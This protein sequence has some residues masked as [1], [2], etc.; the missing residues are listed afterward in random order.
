MLKMIISAHGGIVMTNDGNAILRE[1]A[2]EHPA[3][4]LLLLLL[5]LFVV[6][7]RECCVCVCVCGGGGLAWLLIYFEFCLNALAVPSLSH[8]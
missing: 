8:T 5:L 6:C 1:I 2:A 7:W 4:R 3:V